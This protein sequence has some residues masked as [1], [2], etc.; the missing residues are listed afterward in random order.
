M[1]HSIGISDSY[2]RATENELLDDYLKATSLL[3]IS[4]ESKL[5]EQMDQLITHSRYND[6]S[7]KSELYEKQR[8]I[9]T[10]SQRD[11]INTDALSSL[12][13]Q[14]MKLSKELERLKTTTKHMVKP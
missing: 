4:S 7:I 13:D 3:T 14:V 12:A 11:S 8:L 6:A 1:G 10:I 2:Y 9:D 5:Q